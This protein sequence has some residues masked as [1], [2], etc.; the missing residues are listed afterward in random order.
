MESDTRE[1]GWMMFAVVNILLVMVNPWLAVAWSV[2]A[3][4]GMF[5]WD[6]FGPLPEK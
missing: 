5:L 3:L 2:V 1:L 6:A 4:F